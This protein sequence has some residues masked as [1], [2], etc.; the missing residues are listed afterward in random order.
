MMRYLPWFI[1]I[2]ISSLACGAESRDASVAV[3][4][5]TMPNGAI[6]VHYA[7]LQEP[8]GPPIAIDLRIGVTEGDPNLM[9]GDIRGIDAGSDG[10]IYVLDYQTSEIRA[11]DSVGHYLRTLTRKGSGPGELK[12][13]NGMVLVGDSALWIQDHGQWTMI[14]VDVN[15]QELTRFKMPV[16]SYGYVWNGAIDRRGWLWKPVTV[17][18]EM[19]QYPP[20]EGL[21]EGHARVYLK[22]YDSRADVSD[23][24]YIGEQTY[25]SFVVRRGQ[26]TMYMGIPFDPQT[27]TV[28]DPAGGFWQTSGTPYRIARLNEQGDSVM[29][30]EVA[31]DPL[32]VSEHDREHYLKE[33]AQQAP[34]DRRVAD[35]IG[36]L[37]PKF[38][39]AIA[40]MVLDDMNR[41]WARRTATSD[42]TATYD[43]FRADGAYLGAVTL[44]F[45]PPYLP[46]RIRDG[47]VY[48]VVRDS[49]D[50][51]SVV[52]SEPLPASLRQ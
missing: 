50:V 38:K 2:P 23:S 1:L 46:I 30:I 49:L 4:R 20:K 48:A 18:N 29:V 39:Q 28:V 13:A 36:A 14:A 35:E 19:P 15:G 25:R 3:V 44:G 51:A 41:L 22:S 42:S 47:R 16:L 6:V 8:A 43:I 11:Y 10:T 7:R 31:S 40:G 27:I 21:N 12:A 32:P 45:V 9:F 5:D 37:M 26:S 33:A 52:R 34:G 24:V 17:S